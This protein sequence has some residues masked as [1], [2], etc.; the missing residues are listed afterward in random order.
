M[1][2]MMQKL[3]ISE[4]SVFDGSRRRDERGDKIY[5]MSLGVLI[6][7]AT[8]PF[9]HTSPEKVA[10]RRLNSCLNQGCAGS[11]VEV[12]DECLHPKPN[13]SFEVFPRGKARHES[14]TWQT[15][16]HS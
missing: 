5:L 1:W 7:S 2:A 11:I 16:S 12:A 6:A 3:R 9:S 10:P 4:G 14:M 13:K 8:M 15:L